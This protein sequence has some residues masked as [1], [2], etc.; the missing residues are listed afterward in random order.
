MLAGTRP[1]RRAVPAAALACLALA[2]TSPAAGAQAQ[3]QAGP[4]VVP[5]SAAGERVTLTESA[6]LD[7]ACTYTAGVEIT[8]SNVTL[9][10]RGAVVD[11]TGQGGVGIL[12]H[13]PSDT[14]LSRIA[15]RNCAVRGFLNS[16]RI[17]RDGFRSLPA[18]GEYEHG[19][20]D[21]LIERSRVSDSRGVGIFVDGYVTRTT[22][23]D[24]L[25]TGAGSSGIYLEAGSADNVVARNQIRDNGFRENGPGGSLFSFSGAQF[26][27]WGIG[28][29]GLSIDG[30]RRNLVAGNT[31]QGNSAGGIFLYTNCGEYVRSRPER[32]F[33][34]RY[35]AERNAIVANRFRGG[36]NGVW[37]GSRMGESTLP[38][39]CS[40]TPYVRQGL[41]SITL[42][43]AARNTLW[44]NEFDDVTY[45]VRVEDDETKV[46]ANRFRGPGPTHH[47]VV[48][49]TPERTA[50]LGRPVR[51]TKLVANRS[52]IQG[53]PS[54]YRWVEGEAETTVALNTALGRRTGICQGRTLPRGPFVMTL[55]FAVEPPGA[56]VTPAPDLTV[57]TVGA[58]PACDGG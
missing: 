21:V 20:R 44:A 58:L 47:A 43:R 27:F 34:R 23:R 41:R 45:G 1:T 18:G 17:T 12:V 22:I 9:D 52:S 14:D 36:V 10:C 8:A 15:I 53:N 49:G 55:A 24:S 48:I 4:G 30:S 11:G 40:D 31:F 33:E 16:I 25:V 35:G 3:R 38:M 57:P 5:C 37:V 56:P 6:K 50:A 26:R 13:A 54:P 42:D 46:L 19:I 51:G 7:P 29:E 2:A 39:E 32:W 28:R